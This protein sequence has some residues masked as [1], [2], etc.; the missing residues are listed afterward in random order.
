MTARRE[1]RED[2]R[3][4]LMSPFWGYLGIITLAGLGTLAWSVFRLHR[5]DVSAVGLGFWLIAGLI[6]AAELRPLVMPNTPDAE[7]SAFATDGTRVQALCS[8]GEG[9]AREGVHHRAKN[10]GPVRVTSGRIVRG[11]TSR[12]LPSI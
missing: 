5:H 1:N 9:G 10:P 7:G 4:P 11:V 12:A 3:A 6:V 8:A 2:V